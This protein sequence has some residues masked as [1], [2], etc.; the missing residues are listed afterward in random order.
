MQTQRDGGSFDP[1]AWE[2][3]P[4]GLIGYEELLSSDYDMCDRTFSSKMDAFNCGF[5]LAERP[6]LGS[7]D[8]P[9][10]WSRP[11]FNRQARVQALAAIESQPWGDL[12][13]SVTAIDQALLLAMEA[14]TG[15]FLLWEADGAGEQLFGDEF[16]LTVQQVA[17]LGPEWRLAYVARLIRTLAL[18]WGVATEFSTSPLGAP[19]EAGSCPGSLMRRLSAIAGSPTP[20]QS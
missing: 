3:D 20:G 6:C 9:G 15:A 10:H 18:Y 12:S 11:Q 5:F 14:T 16:A 19:D 1:D 17:D 2:G 13:P 4:E 8:D 7:P